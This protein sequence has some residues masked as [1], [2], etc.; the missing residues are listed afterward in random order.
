M[1]RQDFIDY[2]NQRNPQRI[3]DKDIHFIQWYLKQTKN[4]EVTYEKIRTSMEISLTRA[5]MA[6]TNAIKHSLEYFQANS[7]LSKQGELIKFF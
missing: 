3:T 6:I 4:V 5:A 1:D 2:V 7:I